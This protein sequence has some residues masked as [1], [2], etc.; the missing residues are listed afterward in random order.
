MNEKE[1]LAK[2][3][4]GMTLDEISAAAYKEGISYGEYVAKYKL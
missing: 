4:N 3:K 1:R 2:K